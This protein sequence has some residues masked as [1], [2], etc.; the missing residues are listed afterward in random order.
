MVQTNCLDHPARPVL[1]VL[2][3]TSPHHG[4]HPHC[5]EHLPFLTHL[6][7]VGSDVDGISVHYRSGFEDLAWSPRFGDITIYLSLFS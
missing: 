4:E 3:P 5:G 1:G 7:F 6:G 2:G